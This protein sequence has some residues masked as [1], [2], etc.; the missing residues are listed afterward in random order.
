M[1]KRLVLRIVLKLALIASIALIA[2]LI[3]SLTHK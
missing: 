2:F 1:Y 3:T